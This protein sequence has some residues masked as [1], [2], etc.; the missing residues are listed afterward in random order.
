MSAAGIEEESAGLLESHSIGTSKPPANPAAAELFHDFCGR[1]ETAQVEVT[2]ENR[3]FRGFQHA[4]ID[5]NKPVHGLLVDFKGDSMQIGMILQRLEACG[6]QYVFLG[7]PPPFNGGWHFTALDDFEHV[8]EQKKLDPAW[9]GIRVW[10]KVNYVP[11]VTEQGEPALVPKEVFDPKNKQQG[12]IAI[13]EKFKLTTLFFTGGLMPHTL[14]ATLLDQSDACAVLLRSLELGTSFATIGHGLDVLLALGKDASPLQG[15]K[16]AVFP[17]QEHLLRIHG[18]EVAPEALCIDGGLVSASCWSQ[19]TAE[20]FF[21]ALKL[22]AETQP[23]KLP[24][25][26][27]CLQRS[28]TETVFCFDGSKMSGGRSFILGDSAAPTVAFFVDDVAD[29]IEAFTIL[30]HLAKLKFN[31]HLIS[32][33]QAEHE[34]GDASEGASLRRVKTE[35]VWG[36]TMYAL[37]DCCCE[38]LT[39]PANLVDA[40]FRFDGFF[41]AGGQ[42]PYYMMKDPAI[43]AIMDATPI[44]AAVCHGPEALIGTKWLHPSPS[45]EVGKFVSYYGAWMSFRD[46]LHAYERKKPGEICEDATGRFFTGNAPNSTQAMVVRACE[47]ILKERSD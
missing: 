10:H 14:N 11:S 24:R 1:P 9:Q 33:S 41:V 20:P 19:A 35:T 5:W 45:G 34:R 3:F 47:A 4:E 38:L 7:N 2:V 40:S 44:A 30:N 13:G 29:P 43:K 28:T 42:C 21:A 15:R 36:N 39:L 27:R 16:A 32:H 31:I 22:P 8:F 12:A 37:K 17:N 46:V 23:E 6:E 26:A 25:T 18:V